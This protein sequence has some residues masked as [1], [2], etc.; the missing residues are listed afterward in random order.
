MAQHDLSR[1]RCRCAARPCWTRSGS[2]ATCSSW[3]CWA[4]RWA[5]RCRW[6]SRS[7]SA[8]ACPSP[9]RRR[10]RLAS[11][12]SSITARGDGT[13]LLRDLGSRNGTYVNGVRVQVEIGIGDRIAMGGNTVLQPAL[14]DRFEEQRRGAQKLQAL[15]ELAGGIAHDFNN[16]LGVVLANV[17]HLQ[18]LPRWNEADARRVLAEVADAA[19][20]AGE[21][22]HDLM[23]FARSGPRVLETLELSRVVDGAVRILSRTQPK[24]VALELELQREPLVRGDPGAARAGRRQHRRQRH[25]GDAR[26]RTPAHRGQAP[27]FDPARGRR[28]GVHAAGRGISRWSPWSTPAGAWSPRS[29]AARSSRSSPP[30]RAAQARAWGSRP[31]WR[32]AT[33]AA[34]SRCTAVLAAAPGCGTCSCRRA[35][36]GCSPSAAP[37]TRRRC[38]AACWWPTTSRSCGWRPGVCS[39]RRG[40]RVIEAAD[41]RAAV[42]A[43]ASGGRVDLVLLDLDMPIMD[44]EQALGLIRQL[45]PTLPVLISSGHVE[46]ARGEA[47]GHGASTASSTSP[48]IRSRCCGRSPRRCATMERRQQG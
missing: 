35:A 40:C 26:R 7:C 33:T 39:S 14:R 29:V 1:R 23:A 3:C 19:R 22:T 36:A 48:M 12:R 9:D 11:P 21:L 41:G 13:F 8:A 30:S 31:R 44:G 28:R 42:D 6:A 16:L 24:S 17:S 46:R 5:R 18:S 45:R 10:R 4:P 15:G 43:L 2:A 37:S 47:P 20:R 34:T 27:R 32:S 38:R 25:R